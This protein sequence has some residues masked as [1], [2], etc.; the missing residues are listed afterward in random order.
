MNGHNLNNGYVMMVHFINNTNRIFGPFPTPAK[1]LEECEQTFKIKL[2]CEN[3]HRPV[4]SRPMKIK[5][6]KF[7]SGIAY[8]I[9]ET[10]EKPSLTMNRE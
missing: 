3:K 6:G 5:G 8:F 7:L 4:I 9:I 1:A 2:E 10:L